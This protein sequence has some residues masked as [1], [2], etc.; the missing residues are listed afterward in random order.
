MVSSVKTNGDRDWDFLARRDKV[1][2]SVEI[3]SVCQGKVFESVEIFSV[4][5]GKVFLTVSIDTLDLDLVYWDFR[6]LRHVKTR[7]LKCPVFLNTCRQCLWTVEI[8]SLSWDLVQNYDFR[9]LRHVKTR[10]LKALRFSWHVETRFLKCRDRG[11]WSRPCWK[12]RL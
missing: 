10:F 5:Q 12:L 8:K 9:F 2:E 6:V 11:S 4:C 3:F 7:F 1:F